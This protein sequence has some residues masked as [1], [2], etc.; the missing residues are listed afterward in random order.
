[1]QAMTEPRWKDEKAQPRSGRPHFSSYSWDLLCTPQHL[2]WSMSI[3]GCAGGLWWPQHLCTQGSVSG[4]GH[5]RWALAPSGN[6]PVTGYGFSGFGECC[7]QEALGRV[8]ASLGR[9]LYWRWY[10]RSIAVKN[11][12]IT[13]STGKNQNPNFHHQNYTPSVCYCLLG[14]PLGMAKWI[15]DVWQSH[16]EKAHTG[17]VV[18]CDAVTSDLLRWSQFVIQH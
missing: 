9:C 8:D 7:S 3:T 14:V 11:E 10:L 2:L 17:G 15:S 18:I 5:S 13:N 16:C 4:C 6:L 12:T 1:M